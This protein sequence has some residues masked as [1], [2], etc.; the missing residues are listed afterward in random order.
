MKRSLYPS[1]G[2]GSSPDPTDPSAIL[3]VV[4][5]KSP[6]LVYVANLDFKIVLANRALRE[7]TGYDTSDCGTVESLIDTFY[8]HGEAYT[9]RVKDIHEGWKRNEHI[10]GA[11]LLVQC[12]DGAQRTIA[13]YT[14]RLR[15]GRG[16]TI[17]YVAMGLDLTTQGTLEQWVG[18]LQ[19]T[20]EHLDE[21]VVLTDPGG[22]ILAW[23]KGASRLLGY[24]PEEMQGAPLGTILPEDQR[25]G[26]LDEIDT[27]VN[28][29]VGAYSDELDLLQ[30]NGRPRA[31]QVTQVRLDADGGG[32]LARLTVLAP[33]DSEGADLLARATTL[34]AQLDRLQEERDALSKSE[35]A[36]KA[37]VSTLDAELA[38]SGAAAGQIA[39]LRGQLE[40]NEQELAERDERIS[41]LQ[42]ELEEAKAAAPDPKTTEADDE[43]TETV[44][45]PAELEEARKER[46]AAKQAAKA[47]AKELAAA[48]QTAEAQAKELDAAKQAAEAHA[49]ELDEAKHR[50]EELEAALATAEEATVAARAELDAAREDHVQ[51]LSKRDEEHR[52]AI[53]ALQ[54][55]SAKQRKALETQ[56]HKDILA[57]EERAEMERE[58]LLARFESEKGDLTQAAEIAQA[59]IESRAAQEVEAIRRRLDS[60]PAMD[61][62]VGS[63]EDVA[64]A[65]ADTAGRV[66][67]WSAGAAAL[68]GHSSDE[69]L[70]KVIFDDVLP[71]DGIKWKSLFGQVAIR[72]RV[73][74]SVRVTARNG[75]QRAATLAATMVK[76]EQGAPVGL[77][78]VL[79]QEGQAGD[80]AVFAEA[81]LGRLVTP[82]R[83]RALAVAERG[84][85][86][87]RQTRVSAEPLITLG[88]VLGA[89]GGA[90][91][92]IDVARTEDLTTASKQTADGLSGTE[93]AW[94]ELRAALSDLD[95]LTSV[96]DGRGVMSL[97]RLV[98]SAAAS[99]DLGAKLELGS[100]RT[101]GAAQGGAVPVL[102]G[103]LEG[104]KGATVT[105]YDPG[106]VRVTGT[107][108][109]DAQA[110]LLWLAG[111][112]NLTLVFNDGDAH[113]SLSPPPQP[114]E[115]EVLDLE[116]EGEPDDT[117]VVAAE[118]EAQ[119][120]ELG[121]DEDGELELDEPDTHLEIAG[122]PDDLV[123]DDEP[124]AN[125][126]SGRVHLLEEGDDELEVFA[127]EDSVIKSADAIYM[128]VNSLAEVDPV[129]R[130]SE[131]IL[132]RKGEDSPISHQDL[133]PL[134]E[135][136]EVES[137]GAS[138][139]PDLLH[140]AGEMDAYVARGR[141]DELE[142]A[143][144]ASRSPSKALLDEMA[145]TD[146]DMGGKGGADN[147]D[148]A[149]SKGK[150][151]K[152]RRGRKRK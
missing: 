70:G 123:V 113:L 120:I 129:L 42:K 12:K 17:G 108:R 69:A 137:G 105:T 84:A 111:A 10:M 109:E 142:D 93:R 11:K 121:P 33:P 62:F 125:L 151:R 83:A 81:A 92:A 110:R 49:K 44:A 45:R 138:V 132:A 48:K 88:Q 77:T 3:R 2:D 54:D 80:P 147:E 118:A 106:E 76:N 139:S 21:G 124:E 133:P 95:A 73:E 78:A 5:E 58:K 115:D 82:L 25:D 61:G 57:A 15:V 56:L 143:A 66:I 72:G 149:G 87:S 64:L 53:D 145:A 79:T 41:A 20:L 29:D 63:L 148:E 40:L 91:A 46:D 6:L 112:S 14:S 97:D 74:Q 150:S 47:H 68:D 19:R 114:E 67:A 98:A 65:C 38:T 28:G 50:V 30:K 85:L 90:A 96:A 141:D 13:W 126:R 55:K 35:G 32:P 131:Q 27:I 103:L 75:A 60:N 100:S 7:V 43:P 94:K 9:Q 4:L 8:P 37:R 26:V 144:V 116:V 18:L 102:V 22:S 99:L 51:A 71:L 31:L 134:D 140:T 130:S 122:M 107:W 128:K 39:D 146:A 24:S 34:Q 86:G 59:E 135:L 152:R 89:G 1:P 119:A 136:D 36:L 117:A 104:R 52:V 127:G 101:L 23:N 16:P